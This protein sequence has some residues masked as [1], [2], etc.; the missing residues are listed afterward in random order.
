MRCSVLRSL[1]K[2]YILNRRVIQANQKH[3]YLLQ[4]MEKKI[5]IQVTVLTISKWSHLKICK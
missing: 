5:E 1:F 2:G 4:G 3:S